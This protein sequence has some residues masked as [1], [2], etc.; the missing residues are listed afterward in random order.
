MP[1]PAVASP[2]ITQAHTG[3]MSCGSV[4]WE[5]EEDI[6]IDVLDD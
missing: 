2:S 5:G 6:V 3:Y 1:A 4:T